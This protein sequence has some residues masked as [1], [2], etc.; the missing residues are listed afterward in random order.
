LLALDG[1]LIHAIADGNGRVDRLLA[2]LLLYQAGYEVGRYIS[3]ERIVEDSK[4]TYHESL[5][6][7]STDW[8]EARHDLRP[9]WEHFLGTLTAAH[10]DLE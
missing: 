6:R 1:P 9:W 3:L 7:S 10:G 2:P 4:E 8:H 5:H